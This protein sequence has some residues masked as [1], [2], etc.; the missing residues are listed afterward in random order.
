MILLGRFHVYFLFDPAP[1]R[2]NPILSIQDV[3]ESD[4]VFSEGLDPDP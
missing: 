3:L 2:I 1:F 4:P